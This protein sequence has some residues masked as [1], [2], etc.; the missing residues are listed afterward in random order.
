MCYNSEMSFIF[1]AIGSIVIM[2]IYFS[3]NKIKDTGI[4][5]ILIFYTLMEILQGIQ[6][7]YINQC[8]NI[9]NKILTEI[10]YVLVILQP[11]IW[12]VY[13]FS[14]SNFCDKNIFI[15][16]IWFSIVWITVNVLSRLLYDKNIFNNMTKLNSFF[17][18][19]KVCTKQ[20]KSHLYWEWP[21]ANFYDFNAN[22]FSYLMIWFIP[23]L[24]STKFRSTSIIV[25]I[26]A[27]LAGAASIYAN[28]GI[29]FTALWC[30]VSVPIVLAVLCNMFFT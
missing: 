10:A 14:N 6:Y 28:E 23:A 12:N 9:W 8:S 25:I 1:A 22:F 19:N 29:T 27:L 16:A 17:A 5:Y 24:I 15:T 18:S 20:K 4:Q 3:Q 13:Y 21:S 26:S 30:Y 11:L 2:Y 7:F